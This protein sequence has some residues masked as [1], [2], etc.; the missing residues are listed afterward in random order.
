MKRSGERAD[1]SSAS[2]DRFDHPV[3][4]RTPRANRKGLARRDNRS[5]ECVSR[6][7]LISRKATAS[8]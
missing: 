4:R 6:G 7:A 2:L 1:D 8:N 3:A 5:H